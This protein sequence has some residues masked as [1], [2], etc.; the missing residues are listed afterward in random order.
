MARIIMHIDMNAF[1]AAV[2]QQSNPALR[3]VPVAVVGSQQ[4]TI[5]LT[6]SYEA[7][8]Y[9]VKTGMTLY[10]ARRKCPQL[11]L[12][13][14]NNR[15]YAHV[16]AQIIRIFQDYTPLVEVFSVDEAFLDVSGSLGLFGSVRRIAYLI[17]SRIKIHLGLTCS[18]GIASNKLLAKLA[19]E[20][21]KPDGLTLIPPE[22]VADLLKELPVGEICG[23][24]R[25]TAGKLNRLGI[26]TCGQLG[27]YPVAKLKAQFGIVG[28]R[29]ALMGRGIDHSPVLSPEQ[30]A[31]VKTVG[32]SMTLKQDI[33][34]RDE[35]ARFLLQLS[36]MVG[37]RARRYGVSGRTVTLT[38][39]YADFSTFSRQQI[40]AEPIC[41]SEELYQAALRI[42]DRLLLTQPVRLL[43]VRLSNLQDRDQQLL[44]LP[45]ERRRRQL[46]E[47]LDQVNDRH[48]EFSVMSGS[49]LEVKGKGSH[50]I[51]PAW[52]PAGI[53]NVSFS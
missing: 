45:E 22:S 12:V 41:R 11:Q 13:A 18:V 33:S 39:R 50:V 20:M 17:K 21:H 44:L 49:L 19:S 5:I 2:E 53:R 24:G 25:K 31:E 27:R 14:A 48:G 6:C 23:I 8:A 36:E 38:V 28:E 43:G 37:R 4:R 9:G 47:A 42:L 15:L 32:H 30:E 3:G 10:E 26:F 46:T 40:Q 29:L 35:I 52:R 7:R 1:F 16:S 34:A 51:S